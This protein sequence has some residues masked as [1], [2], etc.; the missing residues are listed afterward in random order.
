MIHRALSIP[1]IYTLTQHFWY[2]S[3]QQPKYIENWIRPRSGDRILDIGCGPGNLLQ[4]MPEVRY[5]GY[6]PNPRYIAAATTR[7]GTRGRFHCGTLT[8]IS[9]SE[10]GSFDV[11]LANGVLHHISDAET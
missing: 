3:G 8:H 11:V 7:F 2:R 5:V 6:D 4:F 9:D 1:W 10:A